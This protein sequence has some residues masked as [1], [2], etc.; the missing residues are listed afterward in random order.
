MLKSFFLRCHI[1][2]PHLRPTYSFGSRDEKIIQN[3]DKDL[4]KVQTIQESIKED[5]KKFISDYDV[6][7]FRPLS[8]APLDKNLK[9]FGLKFAEDKKKLNKVLREN[10]KKAITTKPGEMAEKFLDEHEIANLPENRR[11]NLRKIEEMKHFNK[12]FFRKNEV[13]RLLRKQELMVEHFLPI[14]ALNNDS[15]LLD[16]RQKY[17]DYKENMN[18]LKNNRIDNVFFHSNENQKL[19]LLLQSGLLD[20]E[21]NIN[22]V[23]MK[24]VELMQAKKKES[25]TAGF[26][27]DNTKE[28]TVL[29]KNLPEDFETDKELYISMIKSMGFQLD[30]NLTQYDFEKLALFFE[31][32]IKIQPKEKQ[33]ILENLHLIQKIK[34]FEEFLF[35]Q[36]V[37]NAL[38]I[39]VKG[40]AEFKDLTEKESLNYVKYNLQNVEEMFL[41]FDNSKEIRSP[42]LISSMLQKISLFKLKK[43][44]SIVH[45]INDKRYAA[46]LRCITDSVHA[47]NNRE[48][49]NTVWAI[50]KIH[51]DEKGLINKRIFIVLA[52]RI[53]KQVLIFFIKLNDF[54][55][56]L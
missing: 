49:V 8:Q 9:K 45:V 10:Y 18:I 6:Q 38:D 47:L 44:Y 42:A 17:H 4:T 50:A 34:A 11:E 21:K 26:L 27:E 54:S 14:N 12:V 28:I 19:A 16:L 25:E 3:V 53:T 31:A 20:N 29:G 48:F 22:E 51:K 7:K 15:F 40:R 46:I 39:R 55:P 5:H 1:N 30:E 33:R 56:F 41:M 52:P 2:I 13:I 36:F 24:S 32:I 37:N 43:H 23:I 35:D